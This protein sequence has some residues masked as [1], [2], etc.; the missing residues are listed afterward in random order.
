MFTGSS[1]G[2]SRRCLQKQGQRHLGVR[3]DGK[4]ERAAPQLVPDR[5]CDGPVLVQLH[6]E[7]RPACRA[8]ALSAAG[9]APGRRSL[10]RGCAPSL[11][12]RKRASGVMTMLV[13][14]TVLQSA[15]APPAAMRSGRVRRSLRR[16]HTENIS[17]M[18]RKKGRPSARSKL[19]RAFAT[20]RLL[21]VGAPPRKRSEWT[22][23]SPAGWHRRQSRHTMPSPTRRWPPR[24]AHRRRRGSA[25]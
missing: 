3:R 19:S 2:K 16:P 10:G 15:V 12:A 11:T 18:R 9:S 17:P 4:V 14:A 24:D 21:Y 22:I 25:C 20:K 13:L 7:R 6:L 1:D 23:P 5:A 8:A